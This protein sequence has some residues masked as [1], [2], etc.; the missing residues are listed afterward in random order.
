M[1]L[2]ENETYSYH[3]LRYAFEAGNI[4]NVVHLRAADYE[5]IDSK[6]L[7]LDAQLDSLERRREGIL[8]FIDRD[9]VAIKTCYIVKNINIEKTD[10]FKNV[11]LKTKVYRIF[12]GMISKLRSF[13][14]R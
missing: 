3:N 2:K 7:S 12:A 5:D 11:I 1:I 9:D 8:V 14:G 6:E 4:E 13:L 10:A